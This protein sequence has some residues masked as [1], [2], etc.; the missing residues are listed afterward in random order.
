M[1]KCLKKVIHQVD[2]EN[3]RLLLLASFA[4][5]FELILVLKQ[6]KTF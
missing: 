4:A 1:Y 6:E 3:E 2:S 5:K